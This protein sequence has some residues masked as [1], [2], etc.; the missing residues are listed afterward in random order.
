MQEPKIRN[1]AEFKT[2]PEVDQDYRKL[3][4]DPCEEDISI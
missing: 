4:E 3:Y 2:N 1:L